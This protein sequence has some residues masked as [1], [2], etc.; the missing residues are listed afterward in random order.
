LA[1]D[2][3]RFKQ[4][5]IR[6]DQ[7]AMKVTTLACIQ[8]SW[9]PAFLPKK[10]LDIGSGTGL[11]SLMLAQ[12]YLCSIDTV[13]IEGDAFAQLRENVDRSPWS[14]R[15][16]YHH[17]DIVSFARQKRKM[18]DFIISNP[19]FFTNQLKSPNSKINQARHDDSLTIE[20]L[21]KLCAS[22]LGDH[23][24]ISILLPPSETEILENISEKNS[25]YISHQL[26]IRDS[27][28]KPTK[29]IVS[30]LTKEQQIPEIQKLLIKGSN[31]QYSQDFID[32]LQDYYLNL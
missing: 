18:Y 24:K 3:F 15:I 1:K 30:I 9:I 2:F 6:Q 27:T 31:G 28:D 12:K 11:L 7:C 10:V 26:A 20:T 16:K 13:E 17:Q 19:P 23:G 14:N 22:L 32:L 4:F 5:T 8:G 21:V 25:L 29:A